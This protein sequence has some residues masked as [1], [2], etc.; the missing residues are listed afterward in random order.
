LWEKC[1]PVLRYWSGDLVQKI[2]ETC[3]CGSPLPRIV[4]HGRL[5]SYDYEGRRPLSLLT[6]DNAIEK[7]TEGLLD[8]TLR[9]SDDVASLTVYA[10]GGVDAAS[11]GA[12]LAEYLNRS[13]VIEAEDP[14]QLADGPKGVNVIDRR[15]N[16]GLLA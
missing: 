5:G 4:H 12:E 16:A 8:F 14:A 10:H 11:L 2:T 15:T 3:E 6:L 1:S 9:L 13:P 7:H